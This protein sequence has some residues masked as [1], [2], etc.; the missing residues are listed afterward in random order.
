[1]RI[2]EQDPWLRPYESVIESRLK[3]ARKRETDLTGGRSGGLS[4]FAN[5]HL[6]SR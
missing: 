5:G 1:M 4:D 3:Y 6:Y 2:I